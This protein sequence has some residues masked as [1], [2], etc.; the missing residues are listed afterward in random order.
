[1]DQVNN[2]R[3][4]KPKNEYVE[5]VYHIADIHIRIL[6]RHDE[7][8]EI[9]SKFKAVIERDKTTKLLVICGDIF[10]QKDR[11]TSETMV[12]FTDFINDLKDL[13]DIV[14][15]LGNHD[16]FHNNKSRLD[17][18]SG[19]EFLHND[20][21]VFVLKNSGYYRY[22]NLIFGVSSIV[23]SEFVLDPS[24][25]VEAGDTTIGLYHGY[26]TGDPEKGVCYTEF[27]DY[28]L[29]MLGDLHNHHFVDP[30]KTIGYPGSLIQ[31]S[32]KEHLDHGYIVWNIQNKCG[33]FQIIKHDYQFMDIVV[34]KP[35]LHTIQFPK[36]LRLRLLTTPEDLQ[37]DIDLLLE[38]IKKKCKIVSY[39]TIMSVPKLKDITI[40]SPS[41][42]DSGIE[43]DI[44]RKMVLEDSEAIVALH[45]QI[46][47]ETAHL[48]LQ[49]T[50]SV[51]WCIKKI[52]F[53]NIFCFGD[54]IVNTIDF[55][56]G[57]TGILAT[58][59]AGKTNIL[60]TILYGLFGNIYSRAQNE[61]N[62]NIIHRGR[63]KKEMYVNLEIETESGMIY[64]INRTSK[65]RTRGT[66]T[67]L[68]ETL[69]FRS[70]DES[71]NEST[72]PETE[73]LLRK[74]LCINNKSD[75]ITTNMISNV[76][77][78]G[79]MSIVNMNGPQIDE[80]FNS[81]FNL[82]KFK[83]IHE[84]TKEYC[85]GYNIKYRDY[86]S[87]IDILTKQINSADF[88]TTKQQILELKSR[89]ES[90]FQEISQ[91]STRINEIDVE[92]S[93]STD[94][95]ISSLDA[96]EIMEAIDKN[97]K[98]IDQTEDI[99]ELV[100]H[101]MVYDAEYIK[102]YDEYQKLDS[103]EINGIDFSRET[104]DIQEIT[105][106]I[107]HYTAKKTKVVFNTDI[108]QEYIQAKK[109][110]KDQKN[111]CIFNTQDIIEKIKKCVRSDTGYYILSETSRDSILQDLRKTYI[112]PAE[113][114]GYQK[115]VDD[116]ENR[117]KALRDNLVVMDKLNSLQKELKVSKAKYA[118]KLKSR[119]NVLVKYQEQIDAYTT[120]IQLREKIQSIQIN[121]HIS[122][123]L[124]EKNEI[125]KRLSL[126][127]SE[128]EE[129]TDGISRRSQILDTCSENIVARG[130]LKQ[131][132]KE[133][134]MDLALY[135]KYLDVTHQKNLPKLLISGIVKGISR[136]ANVL[137][138]NATGLSVSFQ[139]SDKWEI[140][141]NKGDIQIGPEHCSGFER[142]VINTSLKI[143]MDKYKQMS[144]VKLFLI[145][146]VIDCV[147]EDNMDN[148]DIILDALKLQYKSILV[149]S[150]NEN[151]K[152]K[153]NQRIELEKG[154]SSS[155][156]L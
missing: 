80:M 53:R 120:N 74:I 59:A 124:G 131:L 144:S 86:S 9:F 6:E 132:A 48:D 71:L 85:K 156:I 91:L 95:H 11:F 4:L 97:Q 19:F 10:H 20:P 68:T 83:L 130:E 73:K 153:I 42:S 143:T 38:E 5:H 140:M 115:I 116:K 70:G 84:K 18:L 77:Y 129:I 58:N 90:L 128:I 79:C 117:D 36:F 141:L 26:V 75:F 13:I 155:R 52:E 112:N 94:N 98:L 152:Q 109:F 12:L 108:S 56:K 46:S 125:Q 8:R 35:L 114:L 145:D 103:K 15:I 37:T 81:M 33:E 54:D 16:C 82:N 118:F 69:D 30:D 7:Y 1:M 34:K 63:T 142:F 127:K 31:Q 24:R 147:A 154:G 76:Q 50:N 110:I 148:I 2:L 25:F 150:H 121:K 60:N 135:K 99:Q 137:I 126:A 61:S 89:Q 88:D 151:L 47:E 107:I 45:K 23:D 17:T 93:S 138:Y 146:E 133:V 44:I 27:R 113:L 96:T 51:S 28:D 41:S 32:H 139:E 102:L 149:I 29:V 49:Y 55:K 136:D 105:R 57:V 78:G 64:Y 119:I 14:I 40:P 21:N 100:I 106:D 72:K 67:L 92:I 43:I 66:G 104:R 87:Q 123:I 101:E 39:K 122:A 134:E 3:I 65:K 62:R 22:D 111:N